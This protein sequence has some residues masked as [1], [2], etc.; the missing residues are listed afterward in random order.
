MTSL[1]LE[2]SRNGSENPNRWPITK[3]RVADA[4]IDEA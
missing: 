2:S 3:Q 4:S 1:G